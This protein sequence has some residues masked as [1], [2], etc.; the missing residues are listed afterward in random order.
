MSSTTLPLRGSSPEVWRL[1]GSCPQE[2][3][4][5]DI[6]R[7]KLTRACG[8]HL[9]DDGCRAKLCGCIDDGHIDHPIRQRQ[10]VSTPPKVP[11]ST[12]M[13]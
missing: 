13:V 3:A 11:G 10:G 4:S 1:E 12:V 9:V 5:V 2:L 8:Q 6:E 7:V